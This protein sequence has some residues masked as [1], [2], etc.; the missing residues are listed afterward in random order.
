VT[1]GHRATGFVIRLA[2]APVA[3]VFGSYGRLQADEVPADSTARATPSRSQTVIAS[4]A[5]G[6][7]GA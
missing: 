1:R 7:I 6:R 4:C 5:S 2:P 3:P